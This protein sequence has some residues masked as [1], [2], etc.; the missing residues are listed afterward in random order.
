MPGLKRGRTVVNSDAPKPDLHLNSRSSTK[1]QKNSLRHLRVKTLLPKLFA[2][3]LA[4]PEFKSEQQ[5]IEEH[6][7]VCSSCRSLCIRN[8]HRDVTV[9]FLKTVATDFGM[10]LRELQRRLR[11]VA[12]HRM[13]S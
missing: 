10:T 3:S 13:K 7:R 4:D 5:E 8:A 12:I 6:I 2:G 11:K 9:P 1:A